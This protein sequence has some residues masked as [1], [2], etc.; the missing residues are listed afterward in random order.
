MPTG[1]IDGG[2]G[3]PMLSVVITNSDGLE[4]TL[5]CIE[6]IVA[7][8]PRGSYEIVLVDN[9]SR[10]AAI[11][12]VAARFP[13][14]R[15]L[16]APRR[17]GFAHNYNMGIRAA[18][19]D[20]ILVLNNDTLVHPGALDHMI[21]VLR[22]DPGCGMVGP[23]LRSADGSPQTVCARPLLSPLRYVWV[24]LVADLGLATGRALDRVAQ[25]RLARRPSGPVPCLSGACMMLSREMLGRIGLLD[26]GY[27]FYY[28]DVEWCRRTLDRGYSVG[29][30]AEAEV[31][32]LGDQ[33]LSKVKV[34][35]KR[36]EYLS[37]LRYFRQYHGLSPAGARLIWLATGLS[38]LLRGIVFLLAEGLARRP[39]HARAYL[40][41]WQW[42]LGAGRAHAEPRESARI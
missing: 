10:V 23:L 5:R 38:W 14:V 30:V 32:H 24:G 21:D 34:W 36:S 15:A 9:R 22:R 29:Y 13:E 31:T 40:Y 11:P 35:A 12:A 19:G 4:D 2:D 17:Q 3:R 8:P 16:L 18:R 28:E 25:R 41:L 39:G 20:Y 42:V 37:A 1:E 7:N 27:D 6:S 33:S 26:E